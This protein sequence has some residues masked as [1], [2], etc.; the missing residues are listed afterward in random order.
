M[1]TELAHLVVEAQLALEVVVNIVNRLVGTAFRDLRVEKRRI[2]P[3]EVFEL[4]VQ[5]VAL[6]DRLRPLRGSSG[7]RRI[8]ACD[9]SRRRLRL[10]ACLLCL[11][12]TAHLVLLRGWRKGI[13]FEIFTFVEVFKLVVAARRERIFLEGRHI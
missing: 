3:H 11:M 10:R 13:P 4:L 7:L 1:R 8:W 9:T 6:V 12:A 5:L 2:L